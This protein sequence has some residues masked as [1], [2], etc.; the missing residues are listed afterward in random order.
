MSKKEEFMRKLKYFLHRYFIIALNGMA[1]GLF[2]I[3]L[4]YASS[5][6]RGY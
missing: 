1:I 3:L 2:A 5:L 4:L 6:G